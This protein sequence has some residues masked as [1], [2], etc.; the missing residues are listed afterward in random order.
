MNKQQLQDVLSKL[1]SLCQECIKDG[2]VPVSC[3][4]VLEDGSVYFQKNEVE[5]ENDPFAHAEQLLIRKVLKEKNT[6]Y[7]KNATLIVSL[8]PC[9]MCMGAMIK[10][11]ISR[12]IY[13]CEDEK[14][15]SL[16]YYHTP[17]DHCLE[18]LSLHDER[19]DSL[20]SYF[21]QKIRREKEE[22]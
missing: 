22:K 21:F 20:L 1:L 3:A 11:G 16:S 17:V 4:L 5:K 15:G 2:E 6:R 14:A 9:L 8:E 12:L 19:F 18:V 7:L 13:L 10:A